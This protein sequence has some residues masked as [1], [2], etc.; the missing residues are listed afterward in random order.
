MMTFFTILLFIAVAGLAMGTLAAVKVWYS[1]TTLFILLVSLCFS[2]LWFGII[3]GGMLFGWLPLLFTKIVIVLC[4][5]GLAWF[6]LN[7]FHPSYGYFPYRGWIHWIFLGAF[8]L[9]IGIDYANLGISSWFLLLLL[10]VFAA[11]LF[12]GTFIMWK[13]K[14]MLRGGP[15]FIYLPLVLLVFLGLI[16]L[17]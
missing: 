17:I 3:L 2:S 12:A 14:S 7:K 13:I 6:F 15:V 1:L 8:F 16:K 11:M 9:L 4:C 10:P 5:L